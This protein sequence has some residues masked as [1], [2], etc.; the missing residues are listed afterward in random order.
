VLLL[1]PGT[2]DLPEKRPGAG[3]ALPE[4][5][6]T[7]YDGTPAGADEGAPLARLHTLRADNTF[8][9]LP[10]RADVDVTVHIDRGTPPSG[11][12]TQVIRAIPTRR[13]L[14]R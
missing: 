2:L 3:D 14:L 7:V 4:L 9:R 11:P 12:V 13:S 8:P 1:Q 10:I 6:I 5:T